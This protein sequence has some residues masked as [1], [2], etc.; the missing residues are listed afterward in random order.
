MAGRRSWL[1]PSPRYGPGPIAIQR[2]TGVADLSRH[3]LDGEERAEDG[4]LA[5]EVELVGVGEIA[6]DPVT[7]IRPARRIGASGE[8][9][10]RLPFPGDQLFG[11]ERPTGGKN[12]HSAKKLQQQF[13][14][15][16]V[17]L[18]RVR[19]GG[20]VGQSAG[21]GA[22]DARNLRKDA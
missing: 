15:G 21:L 9:L 4:L 16:S 10:H 19:A 22:L 5:V 2:A 20:L 6:A 7:Q 17:G 18:F 13:L 3:L 8:A 11:S 12:D 14:A 1:S